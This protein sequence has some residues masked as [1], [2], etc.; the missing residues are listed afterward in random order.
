MSINPEILN[1]LITILGKEY[2]FID[3]QTRNN[4][5]HD[6]TEDLVFPPHVVVK[7]ANALEIAEVLKLANEYKIPTT[8]IGARTGLSG[9]ALSIY[10]GIGLSLERLNKIIEIDEKNLQVVV[11]PAVITQ[12]LKEA[13]ADKGLFYPV[14]PSSMGSCF[15][16]GNIAE[17]SGGARAV[18]YGVTKDYV[19]NL[20]VVLPDGNIIWTGANTLKNSTG[21]NLTQLMVG[22]EGTL[23]V[24]TKIVLKLLPKNNFNILMLVPFYNANEACEAVSAIFRAGI[25][26][27][28]LEFMERDAIDWTMKFVE[29]INVQ[30]KDGINAHLLIEVDGNYPE[31]LLQ[32]AEKI[33]NVV[34]QFEI[35]DILFAD[36]DE[37]KN[38]LWKMRR[39]VA[40]AV[41]GNSVYKEE[42]TV[43]PRF[44]LPKLLEGIKIIG[45]KYG[46]KS[47]CYG[48]AGDGN[49][50]VNIIKGD[51]SEDN[52][53]TQVPLGIRE[54]FE[55]TVSL[56]GTLSGEHGIGLVQKNYMDIAFTKAHL[57][58]MESIKRV[59]DPNNILN[60]GK[61]FPDD[62]T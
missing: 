25:F 46:F 16:G 50:H 59:F 51:M 41:K 55:L 24:I 5:G 4:Y 22:S 11:E 6:E 40:E 7:P 62:L 37:Q 15:I 44:E 38:M 53:K 54:I 32:E 35:D 31:I 13:V 36:T 45:K 12:V 30:V 18:K 47:V 1:K 21:Y 17:N 48:H 58:I 57:E 43:V 20:E 34:E 10:G 60:P 56:K 14:D 27:S 42:D 29:G 52:W 49:L 9:G 39:S 8:P 3:E 33:M 2:V 23:G 28:A 61:I 19:L 26:P